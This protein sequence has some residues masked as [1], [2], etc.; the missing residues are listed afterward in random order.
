MQLERPIIFFDLETTGLNI[1]KDRIVELS[2]IK[3]FPDG[4]EERDT[5]RFN[6]EMK[7]SE[8]VI[9]I[10]GITDDDVKDCPVFGEKAREIADI[11][12]GCYIAG[13]NSNHFDLPLLAEELLRAGVDIDLKQNKTIDVQA[14]FFK[15]EPRNLKAAYRFYCGKDLE[16]AHSANADTEATY[17]VFKAQLERYNDLPDNME[18]L[19]NFTSGRPS[20]DFEGKFIYSDGK[21][22]INFGKHK[23]KQLEE[24]FEKDPGYYGWIMQGEFPQYTKLMLTRLYN[25]FK[26]RKLKDKFNSR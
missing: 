19:S 8:Q 24:V 4:H 12:R 15:K 11:F 13:Y 9:A 21:V 16:K 7:M 6:P 22:V 17:E 5:M 20:A 26:T 1:V 14:I 2:Y 3:V 23:D 10:H 18:R 25:D